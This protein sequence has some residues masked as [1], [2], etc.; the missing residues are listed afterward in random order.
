MGT[1]GDIGCF[2]FFSN[3]NLATGEGGMLTTEVDELAKRLRFL[4]SHGMTSLTYDRHQGHA[5]SYDVV[6]LGYNYR[7]DEIH[8]ALGIEQ[9]KKLKGNNH[10]RGLANFQYRI[11]LARVVEVPFT[12]F[13]EKS[14]STSSRFC[15]RWVQ[16]DRLFRT[17]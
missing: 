10:M 9:L 14:A 12:K 16:I 17:I 2:S 15:C 3:K 13:R 6:A 8:A 5:Y 4:R 1:Y 11:N 7:M